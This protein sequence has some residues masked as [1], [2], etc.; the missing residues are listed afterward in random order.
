MLPRFLVRL[1]FMSGLTLLIAGQVKA[2][3]AIDCF[4]C[5]DRAAFQKRVKHEPAA[6]GDCLSCHSPHVARFAGEV[7]GPDGAAYDEARTVYN[8]MIDRRPA[9]IARCASTTDVVAAVNFAR[10]NGL[11]PAVRSGGHSVAGMSICDDG[12]LIDLSGM[13]SI[14]VDPE[15]KTAR[16]GGGVL[17][18]EFDKATQ[19]HG[20]HTP[21]GRV[22]TTGVGGFTTGGGYFYWPGTEDTETGYP[23]DRTNFGFNAKY[24]QNGSPQGNLL[25]IRHLADGLSPGLFVFLG[26]ATA[27]IS[28]AKTPGSSGSKR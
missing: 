6:G 25:V 11:V 16:A 3:A 27:L 10:E 17:W 5:H 19:E 7:I 13:K 8:A 14:D 2:L 15:A 22:T 20:L 12:I 24:L 4:Q 9:V 28:G 18:G 1:V 21:G 23:G 26:G